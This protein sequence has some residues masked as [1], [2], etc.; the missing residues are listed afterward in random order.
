MRSFGIKSQSACL[1][2]RA[3]EIEAATLWRSLKPS[4]KRAQNW[5]STCSLPVGRDEFDATYNNP[6]GFHLNE[7]G[8]R[9]FAARLEIAG[10]N[11]GGRNRKDQI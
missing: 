11:C 2:D 6:D 10:R 3:P 7:T 4:Q 9:I 1:F 5:A 8:A